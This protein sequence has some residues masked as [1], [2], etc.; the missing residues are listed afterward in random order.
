[1][2]L[3]IE[4]SKAQAEVLQREAILSGL[5]REEPTKNWTANECKEFIRYAIQQRLP[6]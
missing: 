2:K 5:K 6:A 4:I 3:L 1:M